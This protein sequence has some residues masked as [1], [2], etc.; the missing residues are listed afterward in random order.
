MVFVAIEYVEAAQD[1]FIF[2]L[3]KFVEELNVLLLR[4][5]VPSEAVHKL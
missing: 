2:F 4:E 5:M 3:N 1:E